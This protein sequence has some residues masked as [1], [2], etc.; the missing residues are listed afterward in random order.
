MKPSERSTELLGITRSR[1]KMYE[2]NIP[3]EHHIAMRASP[4]KLFSVTVG[5]LGDFAS[6]RNTLP[7][8]KDFKDDES[9]LLFSAQFFDSFIEAK[10]GQDIDPYLL[11]LG[12]ATYYLCDFPG[13]A[14]VLA[15]RI[16]NTC[17]NFGCDGLEV[18][19]FSLLTNSDQYLDKTSELNNLSRSLLRNLQIFYDR[20]INSK[21]VTK[22]TEQ[23]RTLS[24]NEGSPRQLLIG[25]LVSAIVS[26]KLERSS[27]QSLQSFTGI[28]ISAWRD[29]ITKGNFIQEFWPAQILLGERGVFEGKSAVVQMPT[30]AGKTKS[31]EIIIRSSFLSGRSEVAIVVAPFRALCAEIRFNL[32]EAFSGEDV[33]VDSPSDTFQVDFE[34]TFDTQTNKL[35]LVVTPEKLIYML[36]HS[37]ELASSVGLLIYDEGHQFDTG[38]RGITYELLLS[39][40][41]RIISGEVQTILISAVIT[42]AQ[43]IAKWLAADCKVVAG[44]HLH[45]TYRTV[46]FTTWKDNRGRL[47]FVNL[48]DPEQLEYYVPRVLEQ[49]SLEK[50]GRETK[51]RVFPTKSN[52]KEIALYLGIKLV[53]NGGVAIFCGT[54]ASV[55]A[56]CEIVSNISNR[57]FDIEY[58]VTTSDKDEITKLSYLIEQHLGE[59]SV[60]RKCSELGIYA[61]S[62]NTPQGLRLAIEFAMQKGLIKFVI[63]TS[64]LAQGVNLP[65]KYLLITS[66]YQGLEPIGTRDFHNLIG[67]AGRSGI[68][69][70]GS[71]IFAD[72]E[73][74]DKK[75]HSFQN[76]KWLGVK[77]LLNPENSKPCISSILAIFAPF[78]SDDTQYVI[79]IA[80]L[81]YIE[82]YTSSRGSIREIAIIIAQ[83][84]VR[85]GFSLAS[86]SPQLESRLQTVA[87]IESYLM[88]N[89]KNNSVLE[90]KEIEDLATNTLAYHSSNEQVKQQIVKLFKEIAKNVDRSFPSAIKRQRYGKALYGVRDMQ[91][92]ER[93]VVENITSLLLAN[94]STEML[95]AC[96]PLLQSQLSHSTFRKTEPK[97]NV[98]ILATDW[99]NGFTYNT[100]QKKQQEL[101]TYVVA[102]SQR[103]K[104]SIDKVIE[105]CDGAFGFEAMLLVGAVREVVE[106]NYPTADIQLLVRNL[107]RFQKRFKYGV[108]SE[109]SNTF[110]ELGFADRVICQKMADVDK[111]LKRTRRR[112][113][114]A[115]YENSDYEELLMTFP[116]YYLQVF[117]EVK[118]RF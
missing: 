9:N 91:Y 43:D 24:Y 117:E 62:G 88:A 23:I 85:Q 58:P 92:I 38:H 56:I 89:S 11:L 46:A 82:Q 68:H 109:L 30:S 45:P 114:D 4:E 77:R 28:K 47:D 96:W 6:R 69:T 67:R 26:K 74:Y 81:E 83:R 115:L 54:K 29:I 78:K 107:N 16:G 61:H 98:L 102:G 22:I 20:G 106:V 19:L 80:P 103:R 8:N 63:C 108:K 42:N 55:T 35:I 39:T 112:I 40:L 7:S 3:L 105:I 100:I 60:A 118:S 34:D 99:L 65:I 44:A 104:I 51:P 66:V 32:V 93:W 71:I 2:Y 31:I 17:P 72:P 49:F 84:Y 12:A 79:T 111:N 15:K 41:K 10:L 52:G 27:W 110:F 64:T 87:V 94:T 37:P 5:M 53:R 76:Y 36:R 113:I 25:D 86:L 97:A 59:D 33:D 116:S 48:F 70:E 1:A 50:L 73:I 101:K 57:N 21:R 75:S 13:S 95:S 90:E 18:L 14:R